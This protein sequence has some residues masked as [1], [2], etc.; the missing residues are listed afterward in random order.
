MFDT[1]SANFKS[2]TKKKQDYKVWLV[3]KREYKTDNRL[4]LN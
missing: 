2:Q 1:E 3:T 4:D